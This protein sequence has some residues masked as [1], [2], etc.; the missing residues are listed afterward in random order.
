VTFLGRERQHAVFQFSH[1]HRCTIMPPPASGFKS[2][3]PVPSL[4]PQPSTGLCLWILA[5]ER[6]KPAGSRVPNADTAGA[7]GIWQVARRAGAAAV[8]HAPTRNSVR[9]PLSRLLRPGQHVVRSCSV[10]SNFCSL[11]PANYF[12]TRVPISG[13]IRAIG[14]SERLKMTGKEDNVGFLATGSGVKQ[15]QLSL[16]GCFVL[17]CRRFSAQLR[18]TKHVNPPTSKE[19]TGLPRTAFCSILTHS[20]PKQPFS[21]RR[22]I[23]NSKTI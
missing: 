4:T 20:C 17:Q 18:I 9:R 1:T 14:N 21:T 3:L 23:L 5:S 2:G 10:R 6:P 19:F 7:V 11:T 22:N 16:W 12:S 8:N 13:F 15:F